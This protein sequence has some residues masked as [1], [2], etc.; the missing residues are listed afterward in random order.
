MGICAPKNKYNQSKK[1]G[2]FLFLE[3]YKN[4]MWLS[5]QERKEEESLQ[6][7]TQ[8]KNSIRPVCFSVNCG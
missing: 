4:I 2:F 5:N 3:F 7:E 6:L 1:T 8:Y